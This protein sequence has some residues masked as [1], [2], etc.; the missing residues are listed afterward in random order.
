[1]LDTV[2]DRAEAPGVPTA[3]DVPMSLRDAFVRLVERLGLLSA[4]GISS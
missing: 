4:L 1:M 3:P 2:T